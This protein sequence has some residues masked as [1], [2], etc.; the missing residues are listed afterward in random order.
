MSALCKF[1]E[2]LDL[3]RDFSWPPVFAGS[4]QQYEYIQES[5]VL[6]GEDLNQLKNI[7]K[8]YRLVALNQLLTQ[9][10]GGEILADLPLE[11]LFAALPER[12]S[13]LNRGDFST[14]CLRLTVKVGSGEQSV[15][16]DSNPERICGYLLHKYGLIDTFVEGENLHVRPSSDSRVSL[17]FKVT[18]QNNEVVFIEF[19]P[20]SRRDLDEG[21]SIEQAGIR[22]IE[23]VRGGPFHDAK[24]HHLWELD[25]LFTVIQTC[26]MKTPPESFV[27]FQRDIQEAKALGR[28]LDQED[29][30]QLEGALEK[31][32]LLNNS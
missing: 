23:S 27:E 15:Y 32:R 28:K 13:D 29:A 17:D 11:A 6:L 10:P 14:A 21:V 16:F 24:V 26:Q 5:I 1:S 4:V 8:D 19:H 30:Q 7:S 20:L 2:D 25:Q 12:I 9:L 31:L 18:G 22:K 3:S